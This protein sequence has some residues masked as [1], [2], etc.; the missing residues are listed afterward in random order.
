[1]KHDLTL[2][3]RALLLASVI[4]GLCHTVATAQSTGERHAGYEQY[5]KDDIAWL[6]KINGEPNGHKAA[7]LL[8]GRKTEMLP[9]LEKLLVM[10]REFKKNAPASEQQKEQEWVMSNSLHEKDADLQASLQTN[11]SSK[12]EELA[13]AVGDYMKASMATIRKTKG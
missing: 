11:A 2:L 7:E 4:T 12:G 9:R 10:T 3:L 13:R 5:W 8:N 6:Q 1:M